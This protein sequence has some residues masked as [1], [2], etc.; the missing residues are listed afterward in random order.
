MSRA[1][2]AIASLEARTITAHDAATRLAAVTDVVEM[3]F[4]YQKY[5]PEEYG[6]EPIRWSRPETTVKACANFVELASD[7]L[8]PCYVPFWDYE[9]CAEE[10]GMNYV[11]LQALWPAWYE[12]D[13]REEGLT[14]L[15][16]V[17]L[18]VTGHIKQVGNTWELVDDFRVTRRVS[19]DQLKAW[20]SGQAGPL[21]HLPLAYEFVFK[22][23]GNVWCDLTQEE[24]DNCGDWPEWTEETVAYFVKEWA[25]AREIIA[26][27]GEL[28]E[29]IKGSP[30]R[31]KEVERILRDCLID[32]SRVRVRIGTSEE[33]L[34][35]DRA[36]PAPLVEQ[37]ETWGIDGDEIY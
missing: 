5:F 31:R 28:E 27:V 32:E 12:L 21:R 19:T 26:K 23:T 24:C 10:G 33:W 2:G 8:F 34:A 18:P 30:A 6:R 13:C 36:T 7:R 9:Q 15:E 35:G 1:A 29:W 20:V 25:T 3:L 4:V 22:S 37:M 16:Q 11:L 14:V 17:I